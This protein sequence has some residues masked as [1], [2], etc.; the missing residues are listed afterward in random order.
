MEPTK[1]KKTQRGKNKQNK[2][3]EGKI[4]CTKK[5]EEKEEEEK[6]KIKAT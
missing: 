3:C 2:K 6:E 4:R 1:G 5:E